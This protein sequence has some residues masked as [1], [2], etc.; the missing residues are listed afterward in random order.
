MKELFV[1]YLES[2]DQDLQVFF[3]RKEAEAHFSKLEKAGK[4][5]K[6]QIFGSHQIVGVDKANGC[7]AKDPTFWEDLFYNNGDYML[8]EHFSWHEAPEKEG[9]YATYELKVAS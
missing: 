4:P 1:V 5:V 8:L 2:L 7:S 6:M 3:D 9:Y